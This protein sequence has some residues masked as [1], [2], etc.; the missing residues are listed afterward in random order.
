[1]CDAVAGEKYMTFA[2]WTA[3]S[4][5]SRHKLNVYGVEHEQLK[6]RIYALEA[7]LSNVR[8]SLGNISCAPDSELGWQVNVL[9]LKIREVTDKLKEVL[10]A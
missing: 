2:E 6:N 7:Y 4:P 9:K 3:L 1:M 10:G 5:E 8:I